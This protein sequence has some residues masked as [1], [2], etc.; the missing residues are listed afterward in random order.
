[1]MAASSKELL[2]KFGITHILT[3]AKGHPAQFPHSFKY[4]IIPVLDM[5]S[6]NLKRRFN[7]CIEFINEC[8]S[9]GGKVLVHCFAGVSRSATIILAYMMQ[10][11]GL[12]YHAAIKFV[13]N[14]RALI[15]PNDGFRTQ[16]I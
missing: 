9:N 16:L 10:E 4:K 3:V 6:T 5:A 15:N 7:E 13:K 8:L 14:K 11:H 1:M 2:Q 12:S